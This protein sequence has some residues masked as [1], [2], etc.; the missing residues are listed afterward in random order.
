MMSRGIAPVAGVSDA[1]TSLIHVTDLVE[2][3]IA[4]LREEASQ[5]QILHPLRWQGG[6]L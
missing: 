5:H 1:R 6:W 4:C 2:A 3:I